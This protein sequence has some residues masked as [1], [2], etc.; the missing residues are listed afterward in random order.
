MQQE[1]N[2]SKDIRLI[3]EE[4]GRRKPYL[5]KLLK[6]PGT[7]RYSYGPAK[8]GTEVLLE[9]GRPAASAYNPQKE[10]ERLIEQARPQSLKGTEI[11][12]IEG[13]GNTRIFDLLPGI[14][15]ENQICILLE[16]RPDLIQ[17]LTQANP[18]FLRCLLRPGF[19][20]FAG[21]DY[22]PSL[23]AYLD[24]IPS[25]R[26]TGLRIIRHTNSVRILPEYYSEIE[27]SLQSM[28]QSRLSDL[29]TRFEFEEKWIRNILVNATGLGP[30]PGPSKFAW[31]KDR[32]KD[33]QIPGLL[34]AAGPSLPFSFPLIR[35]IRSKVF[36]LAC[37]TAL[38]PLLRAGIVPDAV[39][40]L[41]SQK[42]S[43]L[44]LLPEDLRQIIIFTDIVVHP[45]VIRKIRPLQWVFSSTAKYGSDS[46]GNPAIE[47]TPGTDF[48]E[49]FT[50]ET[51]YLQSGG[52][53]ATSAFDLL[54]NLGCSSIYLAG[55]DLA[56]SYRK[57]HS[58]GTHHYEKWQNLIHRLY[59][60]EQINEDILARRKTFPVPGLDGNDV[61]GDYVLDLYRK[62]F[63]DSAKSVEIPIYNL[64]E[65]GAL[66]EN[67]IRLSGQEAADH[68]QN[69]P[70]IRLHKLI[71]TNGEAR[72]QP[73]GTGYLKDIFASL[74]NAIA[75][76]RSAHFFEDF[77]GL[78]HL[79]RRADIYVKRRS[80][81]P[82][83]AKEEHEKRAMESLVKL[84]DGLRKFV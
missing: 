3:H 71:N 38:K 74:E 28:M 51:G 10:A 47:K 42:V 69:L 58:N 56:W 55:Q 25:E 8:D 65:R 67:A 64:T 54:R 30:E 45:L 9:E 48:V 4:I 66:I 79:K 40:I 36:L 26:F 14:L 75:E 77:P 7:G 80:F 60:L 23:Q 82:Q 5:Q 18:A 52:S 70:E 37:D 31:W 68:F 62:W 49:N 50:G 78:S 11:L 35:E 6:M 73:V 83:R 2:N 61:R 24:S 33:R 13:A 29:L 21:E 81:D 72:D 12:L 46:A 57:L 20:V 19:H 1:S 76:N 16:T 53:V 34:V 59:T 22:T 44:H 39:H 41:D 84:R 15:A 32:F 17:F 63:S 43:L 27:Q